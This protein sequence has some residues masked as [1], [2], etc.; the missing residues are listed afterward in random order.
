MRVLDKR[1]LLEFCESHAELRP[2]ARRWLDVVDSARWLNPNDLK[3][4]FPTAS[5]IDSRRAVFNLK[6]NRYRLL[7]EVFYSKQMITIERV[8][9]HG[10]YSKWKL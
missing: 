4:T 2:P 7:A 1:I 10:E 9:T 5:L 8:G 3:T 6:G